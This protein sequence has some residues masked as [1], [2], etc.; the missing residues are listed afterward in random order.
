MTRLESNLLPSNKDQT[1]LLLCVGAL[2]SCDSRDGDF[3]NQLQYDLVT[4]WEDF[5]NRSK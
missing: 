2:R 1:G 4:S 3:R 5:S